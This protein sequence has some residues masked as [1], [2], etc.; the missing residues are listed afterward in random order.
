M[1]RQGKPFT[2]EPGF[3]RIVEALPGVEARYKVMVAAI[4]YL[5]EGIEPDLPY[6]ASVAFEGIRELSR[7]SERGDE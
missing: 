6:P 4:D 7:C 1:S 2:W 5:S 3:L